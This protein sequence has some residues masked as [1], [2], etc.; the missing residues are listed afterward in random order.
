MK[1]N[2]IPSWVRAWIPAAC[3]GAL[4]GPLRHLQGRAPAIFFFLKLQEENVQLE[5]GQNMETLHCGLVE[6]EG[7]T[8][9]GEDTHQVTVHLNACTCTQVWQWGLPEGYSGQSRLGLRFNLH[10]ASPV[11]CHVFFCHV[12]KV[13]S[14]GW[15]QSCPATLHTDRLHTSDNP[16]LAV[17]ES[18]SPW[19]KDFP[20][21]WNFC[22][23]QA[24]LVV[25]NSSVSTPKFKNTSD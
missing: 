20:F 24:Y 19:T 11:A 4:G 9:Q 10:M 13:L 22:P 7:H 23:L 5:E 8:G 12:F 16:S 21:I 14:C 2:H 15:G 17:F 1:E 3:R 6:L 25:A 18:L